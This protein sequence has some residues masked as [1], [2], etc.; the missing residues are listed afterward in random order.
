VRHAGYAVSQRTRKR[1]EETFGWMKI[2]GCLRRTRYRGL[3]RT[4]LHAYLVTANYNLLRIAR[5]TPASI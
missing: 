2:V 1:V 4:E 3:V 5:L